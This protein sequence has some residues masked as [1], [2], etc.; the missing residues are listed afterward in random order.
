MLFIKAQLP[1]M[2]CD[3][4]ALNLQVAYFIVKGDYSSEKKNE[5]QGGTG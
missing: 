5:F 1:I 2:Y 4:F 3:A